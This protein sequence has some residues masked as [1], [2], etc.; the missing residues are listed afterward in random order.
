VDQAQRLTNKGCH[1]GQGH[2]YSRAVGAED[3]PEV[4]ARFSRARAA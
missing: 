4:V 1:Y 2:L 3:V